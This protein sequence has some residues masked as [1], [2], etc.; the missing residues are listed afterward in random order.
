[1]FERFTDRARKVLALANK[2]AV[3]LRHNYI[4]TGHIL[5]ALVREGSGVGAMT[6][7]DLDVDCQRIA[8]YLKSALRQ[9][10]DVAVPAKLPVSPGTK[11]LIEV[12]T[13]EAD[14]LRHQYVGTERLLLAL[15]R[16]EGPAW[17][18]LNAQGVRTATGT[19][20]ANCW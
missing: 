4:G 18:A 19:A 3:R 7:R 9:G 6:L 13:E 17:E 11:R 15:L 14:K 2:E 12:A 8:A 10:P 1:M 16:V 5:L 20:A